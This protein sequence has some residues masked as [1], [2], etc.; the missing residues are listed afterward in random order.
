M[1]FVGTILYLMLEVVDAVTG[2]ALHPILTLI[3]SHKIPQPLEQFFLR[4]RAMLT[5]RLNTGM[6]HPEME[7]T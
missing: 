1:I 2:Q 7:T 5:D 3:Y 6:Y 4:L